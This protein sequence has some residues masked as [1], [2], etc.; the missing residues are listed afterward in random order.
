MQFMMV[1]DREGL[2][3]IVEMLWPQINLTRTFCSQAV[4][5]TVDH[6]LICVYSLPK[7]RSR[8]CARCLGAFES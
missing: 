7:D 3:H 8:C 4:S 5:I 2:A 6:P 1:D